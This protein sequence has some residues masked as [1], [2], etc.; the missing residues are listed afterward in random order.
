MHG[1]VCDHKDIPWRIL[2]VYEDRWMPLPG[3]VSM[4]V[5]KSLWLSQKTFPT[6]LKLAKAYWAQLLIFYISL[7]DK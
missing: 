1:L 5:R 7:N 2:Q 4:K 6:D 3:P